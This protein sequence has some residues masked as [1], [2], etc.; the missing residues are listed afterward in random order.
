MKQRFIILEAPDYP[1]NL[2]PLSLSNLD[3]TNLDTALCQDGERFPD[4]GR[5]GCLRH[6]PEAAEVKPPARRLVPPSCRQ[7][8]C[9]RRL[10]QPTLIT[11]VLHPHRP[12]ERP[13]MTDST[14]SRLFYTVREAA[15]ELRV[16]PSTLY[17]AIRESAFPAVKIRTR[18]VV[19][20]KALERLIDQAAETG[21]LVNPNQMVKNRRDNQTFSEA[22]PHWT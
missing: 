14:T 3:L 2:I 12:K 15:Y 8:S 18:Y 11:E 16:D 6:R 10:P 4:C 22:A 5:R 19:P 9:I 13:E 1:A 17:R 21:Q 20:R 7:S